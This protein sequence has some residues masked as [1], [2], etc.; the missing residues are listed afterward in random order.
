M[1]LLD[2]VD[3]IEIPIRVYA[4]YQPKEHATQTYPGC[5]ETM[6]IDDIEVAGDELDG[7]VQ[8]F[9]MGREVSM[10][11]L[12]NHILIKYDDELKMAA[13]ERKE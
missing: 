2:F 7:L 10:E 12:K 3:W 6:G 5:P 9:P 13:W 1:E 4:E 11:D 8:P